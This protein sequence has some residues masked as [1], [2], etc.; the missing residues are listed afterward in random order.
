MNPPVD[1]ILPKPAFPASLVNQLREEIARWESLRNPPSEGVISTGCPAWDALLP[2]G[3]FRRGTLVEWLA[4]GDGTGRQ[5]LALHV[6]RQACREGGVV[7]ALDP[8]RNLFPP[9]VFH[10]GIPPDVLVVVQPGTPVEQLW[11]LEQ[12]LRC[13]AVAVVLAG[14]EKL[15][16][17]VFRRLQIAAEQGGS[18]GFLFRPEWARHEPT[19]AEV[20]FRVE[21]RPGGLSGRR[22]VKIEVLRVRGGGA[23]GGI[24]LEIDDEAGAVHLDS[25]MAHPTAAYRAAGA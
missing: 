21:P 3:G 1:P 5:T 10:W 16:P 13:R 14:L 2:G 12:S 7:V 25:S 22:R 17:V 19:W 18:L 8:E 15:D 23:G 11:A 9:A 6:A 4:D 24:E 20:R